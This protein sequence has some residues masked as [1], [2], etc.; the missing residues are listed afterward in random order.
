MV[1]LR[2]ISPPI[3]VGRVYTI[4][5]E[6]CLL[7]PNP[8]PVIFSKTID[9]KMEIDTL[10][11]GIGACWKRYRHLECIHNNIRGAAPAN[12]FISPSKTLPANQIDGKW[13]RS[14]DLYSGV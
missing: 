1:R 14:T 12:R 6:I 4:E 13:I 10:P 9:S 7:N 5:F 3:E 2:P 8:F 11:L